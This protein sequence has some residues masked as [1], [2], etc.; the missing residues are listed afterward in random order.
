MN[1]EDFGMEQGAESR[2]LRTVKGGC[3]TGGVKAGSK[4]G[5]KTQLCR[6]VS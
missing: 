6:N 2:T 3:E 1:G 5:Q 4:Q